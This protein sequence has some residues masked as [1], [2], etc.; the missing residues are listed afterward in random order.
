MLNACNCL[1]FSTFL[2]NLLCQT[3]KD[4]CRVTV[5]IFTKSRVMKN[6]FFPIFLLIGMTAFAQRGGGHVGGAGFSGG[7]RGGSFGGVRG[8]GYAGGIRAGAG[9]VP[10]RGY[11]GVGVR[12]YGGAGYYGH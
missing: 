8:S 9:Y 10:G 12:G 4:I 1:I 5:S 6:I 2:C 3:G 7:A 11:A